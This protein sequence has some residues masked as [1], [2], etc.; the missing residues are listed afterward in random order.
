M[1]SYAARADAALY[2]AKHHGRDQVVVHDRTGGAA[3]SS[4]QARELPDQRG[5]ATAA[6]A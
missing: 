3:S 4:A 5:K 2:E 1:Y 6:P